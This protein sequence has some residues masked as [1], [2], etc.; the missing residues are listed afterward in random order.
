MLK[1]PSVRV[2]ARAVI[3]GVLAFLTQIQAHDTWDT[4]V[5]RSAAAGAILALLEYAT[6]LNPNVGPGK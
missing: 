3:A 5:L 4:A 1:N 2:A 6:P